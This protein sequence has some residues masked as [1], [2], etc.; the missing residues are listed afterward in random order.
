MPPDGET[1]QAPDCRG[2]IRVLDEDRH[3]A[4]DEIQSFDRESQRGRCDTCGLKYERPT[5]IPPGPWGPRIQ[6]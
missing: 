1:C 6:S 3:P 2:N 4:G 5:A